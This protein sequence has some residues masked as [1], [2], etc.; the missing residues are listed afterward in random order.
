MNSRGPAARIAALACFS[1][2]ISGALQ[3]TRAQSG[4]T[5]A[6]P[7]TQKTPTSGNGAAAKPSAAA[8][9]GGVPGATAPTPATAAKPHKTITNDDIDAAHAHDFVDRDE[10][11]GPVTGTGLCDEDC[12]QQARSWMGYQNGQDGDWELQIEAARVKLAA[13]TEWQRAYADAARRTKDYCNFLYQ[14]QAAVLPSGNDFY[15]RV[16]RAKRQ[17]YVDSMGQALRQAMD[18]TRSQMSR[19]T[20]ATR[21]VEPVRAAVMGVLEQ[22]VLSTCN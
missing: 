11:T 3:P 14:Q 7:P 22:R 1:L 8:P 6:N 21:A 2:W 12:A 16:D 20:E 9:A 19:L 17:Q 5:N 18:G 4:S 13:D 10:P 15:A